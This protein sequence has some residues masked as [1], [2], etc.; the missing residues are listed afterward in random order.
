MSVGAGVGVFWSGCGCV[1][2]WVW[3]WARVC[4]CG[5]RCGCR[6]ERVWVPVRAVVGVCAG[7]SAWCA[8]AWARVC[9]GLGAAFFCVCVCLFFQKFKKF[10]SLKS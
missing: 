7:V 5:R 10:Q 6:C 9:V 4:M 8:G 3:A 2:V 1:L